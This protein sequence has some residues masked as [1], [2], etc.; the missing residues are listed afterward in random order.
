M[1][2][3]ISGRVGWGK[4]WG[5][6]ARP[7]LFIFCSPPRADLQH[8]WQGEW[9]GAP[10]HS[11]LRATRGRALGWGVGIPSGSGGRA[12]QLGRWISVLV[13]GVAME[14]ALWTVPLLRYS[15]GSGVTGVGDAPARCPICSTAARTRPGPAVRHGSYTWV[16]CTALEQPKG[17]GS[18]CRPHRSSSSNIAE[19]SG[20]REQRRKRLRHGG[21]RGLLG[22]VRPLRVSA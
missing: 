18:S 9:G 11:L 1:N 7:S 20:S 3:M 13:G 6:T 12:I 4:G 21:H 14:D 10:P 22:S 19:A 5:G 17:A 2:A 16:G 15:G 8:L